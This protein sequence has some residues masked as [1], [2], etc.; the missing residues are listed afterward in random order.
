[1]KAIDTL[2]PIFIK[3]AALFNGRTPV[4]RFV[5]KEK[6]SLIRSFSFKMSFVW[7]VVE[8]GKYSLSKKTLWYLGRLFDWKNF[9]SNLENAIN[10]SKLETCIIQENLEKII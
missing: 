5:C 10:G 8:N 3:A 7:K 6:S 1:V 4:S 2:P 9:M